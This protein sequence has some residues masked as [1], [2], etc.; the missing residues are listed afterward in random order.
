MYKHNKKRNIGLISE[1]FSRYMASAF[2]DGRHA[3]IDKANAVWQKHV[4]PSSE[5]HKEFVLFNALHETSLRD[6]NVAHSLLQR[7]EKEIRKQSQTQLDKEKNSLINEI[8]LTL[9]DPQFFSRSVDNYRNLASIQLLFNAWRGV[10]FKGS[11]ADLATL[12]ESVIDN[13][14]KEKPAVNEDI[15][16]VS[17]EDVDHLVVRMMTEKF[18]RKYEQTLNSEQKKIVQLHTLSIKD[19]TSKEKLSKL[20]ESIRQ[21]TLSS[22]ARST[23]KESYGPS[24]KNKLN[25]IKGML[26][27]GGKFANTTEI[28]DELIV[29]YMTVSKLK[30]E[31]ESP[32]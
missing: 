16:N 20:L 27:E 11:P 13:M 18:N 29:F 24:L 3:D 10:G 26:S 8:N 14:L 28:N 30:E 19:A 6:R 1:F 5:T 9:K 22:M 15:A 4:S 2:V 23:I 7:I 21:N 17:S 32:E 25:E 12:E 31:M